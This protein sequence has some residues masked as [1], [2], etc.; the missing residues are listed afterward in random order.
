[1]F[2]ISV[3][4]SYSAAD[5]PVVD[6]AEKKENFGRTRLNLAYFGYTAEASIRGR[7][8]VGSR[9][10]N[11]KPRSFAVLVAAGLVAASLCAQ[12]PTEAQFIASVNAAI[13]SLNASTGPATQPIVISGN[14][15]FADGKV[16]AQASLTNLL[17]FVDG[18]KAAGAQRVDLNPGI[19]SV[20][21]PTTQALLDGVVSH[22]RQLG[23]Q[24]AINPEVTP[25][26]L[27]QHPTFE[28]FQTAALQ[29]YPE[30]AARYQPENFVI[31]HEPTTATASLALPTTSVQQ[32]HDFLT[33]AA[34]LIKAASP[35]TRVG[36]GA[37]QN[38]VLPDLSAQENAF[39]QDAAAIPALDFLTMDLYNDDTFP[40]YQQWISLAHANGKGI[41]IEET[42]EPKYLPIPL[43]STLFNANGYLTESLDSISVIGAANAD[44]AP[45]DASWQHAMANFASAN[46][47][48][49]LT[50]FETE[51]FFA[52]GTAGHDT[53]TDPVYVS[54]VSAALANG[55]LTSTGKAYAAITAQYGIK[56]AVSVSS[57]SYATVPG[58]YTVGCG[59]ATSPCN[60]GSSTYPTTLGGTSLTLVDSSNASYAV[61]LLYV[62]PGQVN[63]MIPSGT[64]A[65]PAWLTIA[66]GDGTVSQGVLL[67]AQVA[68]GIYSANA[69]G[70][71]V[72]AAD[73][74]T[75][76]AD[77]SQTITQAYT[78]G[79]GECEAQPISLGQAGDTVYLVLFGTGL[80]H[81][82]SLSA[83]TV[84]VGN[85]S[86]PA[87]YVGPQGQ[88]PGLDQLNVQLPT[89][90]AG[91][92]VVN[93]V[94]KTQDTGA[95]SNVVTIAIQ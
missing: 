73:V 11:M 1:L 45:L 50:T 60:A 21:N 39:F 85:R 77:Q 59:P 56:T 15:I 29:N 25:G 81:K 13:A 75:E 41:Y 36:A 79:S 54:A 42:G 63:Y 35:H 37:Y 12:T 84:Q 8:G 46:G 6:V 49:A 28:A 3:Q 16:L 18:L 34:P 89:S 72:A 90:L 65:G 70:Q 43:P 68:P 32:W 19:T 67:V 78:C 52:L 76:H 2:Q 55:Q 86:L 20:T 10:D 80:R 26:E 31:V 95:T 40:V 53:E 61:P 92:G 47:L 74:V 64:R 23:M 66:S 62:A 24:L 69:N 93:V 38:G 17:H 91:S 44:F 82:S 51:P 27:G 58:A 22:I 87:V 5:W 94:V 7:G 33:A 48:E 57:A 83:V 88:Y 9:E 4:N 71:G 30:L 14:L